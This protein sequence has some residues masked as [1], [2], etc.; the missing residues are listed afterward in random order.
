M[1]RKF[2]IVCL[3]VSP[4]FAQVEVS[5]S[6]VD[7][8][9]KAAI[10]VKADREVIDA[11]NQALAAKEQLIAALIDKNKLL[12]AQNLELSKLKCSKTSVFFGLIKATRCH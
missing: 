3:L 2:I 8:A 9:N 6:F 4:A 1:I 11:K 12:E 5:Q 7:L 10:E